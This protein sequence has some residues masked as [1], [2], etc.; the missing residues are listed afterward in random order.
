MVTPDLRD[1]IAKIIAWYEANRGA[2][3]QVLPLTYQGTTWKAQALD[4]QDESIRQ[5]RAGELRG[6]LKNA[7]VWQSLCRLY[8][9]FEH[10][11]KEI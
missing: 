9:G 8:R 2:I 11:K 7:Y 1:R 10:S 6:H 5:Y 3:A 4:S